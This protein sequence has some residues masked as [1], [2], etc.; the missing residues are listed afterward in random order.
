MIDLR[1]LGSLDLRL[2]DG[3]ALLSVLAQPKRTALLCYLALARPRGFQRRDTLLALFWPEA[4]AEHAR[5]SLRQAVHFL[6]RSLGEGVIA[7][8]GDDDLALGE[9]VLEC[10]AVAFEAALAAGERERAL[11]LY[12]GDLLPGFH[13]DAAPDFERWLEAER[14]RLRGLAVADAWA[15]AEERERA[16]DAGRAAEWARAAFNLSSDHAGLRRLMQTLERVGDSHAALATYES[17]ARRLRAEYEIEPSPEA[18][19]LADDIR[20]RSRTASA[21]R[22]ASPAPAAEAR[23][24]QAESVS[25]SSAAEPLARR[26]SRPEAL[27]SPSQSVRGGRWPRRRWFGVTA[28]GLAAIALVPLTLARGR[29]RD[30]PPASPADLVSLAVLPLEDL[31]PGHDQGYFADGITE[32]LISLLGTSPALR[33]PGRTSSFYFRD[34]RLPV[35]EIARQL[36]VRHVLEGS[37][38][39]VG[40]SVTVTVQ[41]TDAETG[42]MLRSGSYDAE[43]G[44]LVALQREVARLV[45]GSLGLSALAN[46]PARASRVPEAYDLYLQGLYADEQE[47]KK[48]QWTMERTL[49]L[50]RRALDLDPGFASAWA[51][52]AHAYARAADWEHARETARLALAADST[53]TLARM[54]LASSLAFGAYR[55]TEAERQLD[56]AI[57]LS[58]S[59]SGPY[60]ARASIRFVLGRFDETL[61]DLDHADRLDPFGNGNRNVR[62][63]ML[64][65]DM[66]R[67]EEA[68]AVYQRMPRSDRIQE[69]DLPGFVFRAYLGAGHR[70]QAESLAVAIGNK[71][72]AILARGDRPAILSLLRRARPRSSCKYDQFFAAMGMPG[73]VVDCIEAVVN[74]RHRFA[75]T[76]VRVWS[77]D[78]AVAADPR[79]KGLM[80]RVGL[81]P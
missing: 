52:L 8:R 31:S 18:Q 28:V 5:S 57:R 69:A 77:L 49:S 53:L 15:L 42:R 2:R 40:R 67:F 29:H 26:P 36:G 34:K 59:S 56:R 54:A 78:P 9:G 19:A 7:A 27:P 64:L 47:W 74:A 35:K 24:R 32:E 43:G 44:D 13:V 21:P 39:K 25:A 73:R 55:W 6:R 3:P 16:G 38:R 14:A 30:P 17:W 11:G 48:G 60:Q 51:G 22:V 75:P 76:Y 4:D 79:F 46:N 50:Y 45:T 65:T 70:A 81:S 10:D 71:E 72:L 80:K 23:Q 33:V 61:D 63:V 68:L 37:V 1:T 66:R 41:L 62:R 12:R 20:L 58:P